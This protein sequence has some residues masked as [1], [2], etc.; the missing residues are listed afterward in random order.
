MSNIVPEKGLNFN[1]YAD[2]GEVLGVAE[3]TLPTIEFMTSE[4]KGAG[5]AGVVESP[6]MG[7]TSSMTMELTWR[8][9]G[10]TWSQLLSPQGH[11]LDMYSAELDFDAGLGQY[12]TRSVHVYMKAV[13]K[14]SDLGK[15]AVSESTETKTVHEIYYLKLDIDNEEQLVI[16]KYNYKYR[17]KGVDYMN[18][19]RTALGKQ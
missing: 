17:V 2:N 13:T 12:V 1:V 15:L 4:V 10:K 16:D 18:E 9:R 6:G 11:N 14:N 5:I 8:N 7:Q 19:I 3:G